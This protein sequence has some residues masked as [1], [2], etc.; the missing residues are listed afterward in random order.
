MKLFVT[1]LMQFEVHTSPWSAAAWRRFGL[2]SSVN[3]TKAA[4]SPCTP[5]RRPLRNTPEFSNCIT[6]VHYNS[7]ARWIHRCHQSQRL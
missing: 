2:W 3:D 4:S 5:G 1:V 6:T 7:I